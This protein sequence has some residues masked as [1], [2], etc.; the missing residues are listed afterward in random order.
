MVLAN[1]FALAV[2]YC[3]IGWLAISLYWRLSRWNV[4]KAQRLAEDDGLTIGS[5]AREIACTSRGQD[6]HL[7]FRDVYT[8]VVFGGHECP[9]CQ[10]LISVAAR[11]PATRG[12][13]LVYISDTDSTALP[14][15]ISAR[16][17]HYQFHDEPST[18]FQWRAPVSPYFH[19]IDPAGSV[20]AK[21]VANKMGHLDRL[22]DIAPRQLS[23]QISTVRRSRA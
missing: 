7:S 4:G 9:P 10:E 21:G 16:W 2:A 20:I 15:S 1:I 19:V 23:T 12:M 3:L 8:L 14:P 17:E 13:R 5:R 11:H 22:L 6:R 18:R